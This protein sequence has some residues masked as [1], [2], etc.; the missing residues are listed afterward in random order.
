MANVSNKTFHKCSISM[1][2]FLSLALEWQCWYFTL[3]II[4]VLSVDRDIR[5]QEANDNHIICE[6]PIQY[7]L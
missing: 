2:P 4:Y 3:D 6:L 7:H 5:I 1:K